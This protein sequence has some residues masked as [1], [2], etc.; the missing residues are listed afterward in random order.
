M[1]IKKTTKKQVKTIDV[2]ALPVI[3]LDE[4][5]LTVISGSGTIMTD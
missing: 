5:E 1:Q 4:K 2:T 3:I